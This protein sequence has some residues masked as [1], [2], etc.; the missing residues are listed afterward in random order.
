MKPRVFKPFVWLVVFTLVVG[1]ACNM[2]SQA[3][4]QATTAPATTAPEPTKKVVIPTNTPETKETQKSQGNDNKG[5]KAV[6][7]LD[8][9]ESAVIQI[10]AEGTFVDPEVGWQVNVGKLGSGFIIDPSGIAV[11]NNHVVTGAA[12]LKV[13]VGGNQDKVYNARVLGVSEC[14]D[15]AVIQITGNN[16]PYM[17]WY[18]GDI[19]VGLKVYAAGF[20]FGDPNYNLTDGIVSKTNIK[21]ETSW[22]SVD[23][24]IEHSAKINPGNS[25]G[26]LVTDNGEIVGINYAGVKDYDINMAIGRDEA[27]TVIDQL[28]AGKDVDSVGVNGGAVSGTV[29]DNVPISGV[30]VRS[31]AS[32]S[33]AD[34]SGLKPGDIIYQLENE[35]LA[36]DGTMADYCDI[37]RSRKAS[38][39]M[40]LTVIRFSDLS[41]MEGQLNGRELAV[42]GYFSGNGGGG[43]SNTNSNANE[44]GGTDTG[45]VTVVDNTG[46]I[47]LDVPE[48]WSDVNGNTWKS[49]WGGHEFEAP[50]IAASTNLD[51]FY[52]FLAPGVFFT[53]SDRLGELGGNQQLL[54]GV[55][56]WYDA[57]CKLDKHN[58][59]YGEGDLYDKYYE[60]N[61]DLWKNCGPNKENVMILAARPKDNPTS[62]LILVDI[63]YQTDQDL[64][65]LFKILSTF[66]VIKSF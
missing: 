35:V 16:F 56:H 48:E 63:R 14:S 41:L 30:W 20:P 4:P 60:G 23:T 46:T 50:A 61:Y 8:G 32:G 33:P 22:A 36:T 53:A 38:D 12:L 57:D 21:G 64:Q 18:D 15:L 55:R 5:G 6:S 62:F 17:K 3:Q 13:W 10:A 1:L 65:H 58:L 44:N 45:Y 59:S 19:K 47:Q 7:S 11:T 66:L 43:D 42:T 26:P 31:V 39:T 27:L 29:S 52:K 2:T 9:V 49:D 34:K 54:E 40:N 24:V 28:K 51:D 37:L 25:G